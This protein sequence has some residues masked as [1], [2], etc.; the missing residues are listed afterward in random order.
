MSSRNDTSERITRRGFVRQSA[1]TSFLVMAASTA[2]G[3]AA[4]SRIKAGAIGLGGRGRMIASMVRDH[5]GYE[6]A[7][8][9]DYF[10]ERA[11]G[12]GRQ[13]DVPDSHCFSGL[14]GYRDLI[15]S[16]VEAVFLETPPYFFPQH[17]A[18]ACDA[19]LHVYMAKPVAV[20]VPGC[21]AIDAA[22]QQAARKDRCFFVDYQMPTD[23]VNI[24]VRQR[25][26]DGG[27]GSL[28]YVQ[29]YGYGGG[30][31]DPPKT[32]TIESR[33]QGLIWVNDVA[34]GGDYIVNYD[35]H[36]VDAALWVIGDNPVAASGASRVCRPEPHGDARDVCSVVYEFDDGLVLNHAAV[37][38]PN[39]APGALTCQVYGASAYAQ[40]NYWGSAF[41]R[42][43]PKEYEGGT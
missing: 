6:I 20:D 13:F 17:A 9:A 43:G 22:A 7:A 12:A 8:V 35:I 37:A 1:A 31:Q 36:A 28:A 25:I 30:F 23:P 24:E 10:P 21:L 32:A 42:G 4:N 16:G 5:G 41:L 26:L 34:L 11:R 14:S 29:T 39:T 38:L 15:A 3:S 40:L 2:L 33:L 18:A 27:L 19:G